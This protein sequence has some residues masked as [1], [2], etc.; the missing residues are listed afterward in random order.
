ME[1]TAAGGTGDTAARLRACWARYDKLLLGTAIAVMA[2]AGLRRLD[3]EFARLL[4]EPG[5]AG[6][7]DL[8]FRHGEIHDWFAGLPVY[9]ELHW[10]GY[11]PVSYVIL[12]PLLG[13]LSVTAARWLWAVSTL[14]AVAWLA[15]L[16]LRE[17]GARRTLTRLALVLLLLAAH[18]TGHTIGNGQLILHL[19]PPLI[20]AAL[21]LRRGCGTWR[22]DLVAAALFLAALVKPTIAVPFFWIVL[23]VPGRL[24]PAA[25]VM[26]GYLALS[27]FAAAF[28]DASLLQL[29]REWA[30]RGI[31]VVARKGYA[32]LHVWLVLLGL[33]EWVLPASLLTFLALGLWIYRHREADIW[34]LLGISAIAARFWT[35]HREY[36]DLLILMPMVALLRIARGGPHTGG[37]DLTAGLLFALCACA[38]V[39]SRRYLL[40]GPPLTLIVGG[41]ETLLWITVLVFLLREPATRRGPDSSM[42]ARGFRSQQTPFRGTSPT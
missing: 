35:Y 33:R 30:S 2:C 5:V 32:D 7:V 10:A 8:R 42:P 41:V 40:H 14:G 9:S 6:A 21:L 17:G 27:F 13:W 28:Q 38:A 25:L 29:L 37:R 24:R 11:P 34:L 19:L 20:T 15:Y 16:F 12:W 39:A 4:W 3:G 23:F 18:P 36:D 26:L 1:L 31:E 22:G